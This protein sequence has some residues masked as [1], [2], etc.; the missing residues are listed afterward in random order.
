MPLDDPAALAR[1]V[2]ATVASCLGAVSVEPPILQLPLRARQL[3]R[4]W[5]AHVAF[6][7]DAAHSIH[8][9]AGQGANLGLH[10][11]ETL[12]QLLLTAKAQDCS[13]GSNQLLQR[14][15]RQRR[16]ANWRMCLACDGLQRIFSYTDAP[17]MQLRAWGMHG[18]AKSHFLRRKMM[19]HAMGI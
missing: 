13:L 3:K 16:A 7:G 19:Q 17:I 15:D 11:A 6:V 10:D 12:C 4:Y 2:Q 5:S 14:Y 9:L 1:H 8:P 18:V